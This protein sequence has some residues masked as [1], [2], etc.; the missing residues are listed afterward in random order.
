MEKVRN[1]GILITII[2]PVYNVS[3][4]LNDCV[5]S[6]KAQTYENIEI[7]LVDDG[8]TDSSGELCDILASSDTRIKVIHK[9]N[10]GLS[11]ARNAGIKIAKG[12]YIGFV[13]SDDWIDKEMY[14]KLLGAC[15]QADAQIGVCGFV[16]EFVN[17]S[18]QCVSEDSVYTAKEA[19]LKM[20]ENKTFQDHACTKLFK[21]TLFKDITFPYKE[22]YED[23]RTTYKLFF[24]SNNIVS[25]RDAMYHYRQRRGSIA[26]SAFNEKRLQLL[27]AV[28]EMAADSRIRADKDLN[29]AMRQRILLTECIIFREILNCNSSKAQEKYK[30]VAKSYLKHIV[31]HKILILKSKCFSKSM[32]II[33][34][35]FIFRI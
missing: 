25:V 23:A 3:E 14:E 17:K 16:K 9:K 32:K 29:A 19:L 15:L 33:C 24:E 12:E 20:I 28:K 8:S 2:V 7:I 34:V 35:I 4:Y 6:L 31:K 26:K 10:G 11:D 18:F 5:K 21:T 27:S 30:A 1:E 22:L 13:D